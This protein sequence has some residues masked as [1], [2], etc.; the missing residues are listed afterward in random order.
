[1]D[2]PFEKVGAVMMTLWFNAATYGESNMHSG[3]TTIERS[4]L[5][6]AFSNHIVLKRCCGSV[7]VV[8]E[9]F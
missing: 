6:V 2:H 4:G 5:V 3:H 9:G 7:I 1:M 8:E